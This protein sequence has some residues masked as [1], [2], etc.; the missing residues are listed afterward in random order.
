MISYE[1]EKDI[2]IIIQLKI[3]CYTFAVYLVY[4]VVFIVI[5]ADLI[6]YS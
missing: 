6:L 2:C 3:V 5:F 1:I 4:F